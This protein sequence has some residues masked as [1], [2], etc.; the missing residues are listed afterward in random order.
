MTEGDITVRKGQNLIEIDRKRQNRPNWT[1]T[2]RIGA[3]PTE[4]DSNGQKQTIMYGKRF[5]QTETD[6]NFRERKN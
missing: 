3:E 6:R 2:D 4:M 1:D 5:K